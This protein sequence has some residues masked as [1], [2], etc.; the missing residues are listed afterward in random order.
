MMALVSAEAERIADLTRLRP[1]P[2]RPNLSPTSFIPDPC[3]KFLQ[4]LEYY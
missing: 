3:S 2:T 1:G 4:F